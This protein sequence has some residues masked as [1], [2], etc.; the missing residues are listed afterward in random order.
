MSAALP[1][2][3]ARLL[4]WAQDP[5]ML[6]DWGHSAVHLMTVSAKRIVR[7]FYGKPAARTYFAG[8]STGGAEA[9]EEAQFFPD[10]YDGIHARSPG[11]DYSHVMESFFGGGLLPARNPATRLSP[12]ALTLL[13]KTVLQTCGGAE[14]ARV[15]FLLDPHS[16][17]FN[18]AKLLCRGGQ[19][20]NRCLAGPQV[21][22]AARLYAPVTDTVSGLELYPGFA[23]GSESQWDLIQG[24]L[25]PDYAQPL[26]ANA[27]FRN[28]DW[29]WESF[30]FHKD[31]GR[32]DRTLSPV[33]NA[34]DPDLRRFQDHGGKLIVTQGWADA[35][36][37]QTLP[38]EYYNSVVAEQHSLARTLRFARLFMVPGMSHCGHG[39][40]PTTV[41]GNSAPRM[42]DP[43]HDVLAALQAWVEHGVAPN[44]LVAA[45]YNND[46]A[47]KGVKF[48]LPVCFYPEVARYRGTGDARTAASYACV[49]DEAGFRKELR[50]EIGHVSKDRSIGDMANLPN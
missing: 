50:Q 46:D 12:A 31:A 36:N 37:A 39:P 30:D 38:I 18:P 25:I 45:K 8:C 29:N 9:M 35:L 1:T 22:E 43:E 21:A 14:A 42:L 33:I 7:A 15:G 44:R 48:E 32:V 41:G 49:N 11:Q 6:R 20:T 16:C 17:H 3:S 34:T 4:A 47:A 10:D 5:V 28:P 13:N 23:R 19:D 24:A 27:L 26:L 40:G 2:P